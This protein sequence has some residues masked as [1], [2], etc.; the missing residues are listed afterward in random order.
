[1]RLWLVAVVVIQSSTLGGHQRHNIHLKYFPVYLWA[2]GFIRQGPE[3]SA[4]NQ[5]RVSNDH[6]SSTRDKFK[7]WTGDRDGVNDPLA[8]FRRRNPR[9][10]TYMVRATANVVCVVRSLRWYYTIRFATIVFYRTDV[11][12]RRRVCKRAGWECIRVKLKDDISKKTI[13]IINGDVKNRDYF[14]WKLKSMRRKILYLCTTRSRTDGVR[15]QAE[16][17]S[18]QDNCSE[19]DNDRNSW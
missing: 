14:L 10:C 13:I 5:I 7:L 2:R 6:S 12:R 9:S 19:N 3:R 16:R 15:A 18:S 4:A 17:R 11:T 8:V 1:M